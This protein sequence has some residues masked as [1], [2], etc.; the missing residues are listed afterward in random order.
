V[1]DEA[2]P[3]V[4]FWEGEIIDS[5]PQFWTNQWNATRKTDLVHWRRFS[6]FLALCHGS[7]VRVARILVRSLL[8]RLID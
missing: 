6:A 5:T 2:A 4:T 1:P 3:V 7:G 8:N